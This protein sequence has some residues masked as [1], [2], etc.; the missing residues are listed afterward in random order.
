MGY[1]ELEYANL[2]LRENGIR[3]MYVENG[4][5]KNRRPLFCVDADNCSI[6]VTISTYEQTRRDL[7]KELSLQM[8]DV[9]QIGMTLEYFDEIWDKIDD[10]VNEPVMEDKERV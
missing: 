4:R 10:N 8:G 9:R 2:R 1:D 6:G 3:R 5:A 7:E